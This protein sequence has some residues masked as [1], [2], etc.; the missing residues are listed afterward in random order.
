MDSFTRAWTNGFERLR[1]LQALAVLPLATF[2]ARS[3]APLIAFFLALFLAVLP[4][5]GAATEISALSAERGPDGVI[6]SAQIRLELPPQLEDALQKGLP[7]FFVAEATVLRDRWYWTDK[8]VA[9]ATR[10]LRLAFHPL[11]RRWRLLVSNSPITGT[12]AALGQSFESREEALAAIERI[13]GWKIADGPEIDS[14]PRYTLTLRFR[15]D[16]AQRPRPV[17]IGALGQE[18]AGLDASRSLRLN[19]EPAR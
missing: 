3:L 9:R 10:H 2:P 18:D 1:G 13:G 17:Q 14:A 16:L 8:E 6:V 4:V 15:L 12:G 5:P 7:L 19:P 11:T